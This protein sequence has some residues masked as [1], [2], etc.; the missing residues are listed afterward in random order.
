VDLM[1]A[2]ERPSA[3]VKEVNAAMKAATKGKLKS[4]LRYTEDEICSSDIVHVRLITCSG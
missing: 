3:G 2:F 1:V 4:I